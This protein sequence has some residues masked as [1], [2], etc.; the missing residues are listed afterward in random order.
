M[1]GRELAEKVADKLETGVPLRHAHRDYCGMG[2]A[3]LDGVFVYAEVNDGHLSGGA[4]DLSYRQNDDI[5]RREFASRA[6]FV[7]WLAAQSDESLSGRE[8]PNPGLHD[9]QRIT[10]ARL[11]DFLMTDQERQRREQQVFAQAEADARAKTKARLLA[12]GFQ[13]AAGDRFSI[14]LEGRSCHLV[15]VKARWGGEFL[16]QAWRDQVGEDTAECIS[17]E[18]YRARAHPSGLNFLCVFV[19]SGQNSSDY[20]AERIEAFVREVALPWFR[21][22]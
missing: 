9:N 12:L 4:G 15:L 5:E 22:S 2:L 10:V 11:H 13:W 19:I 8:L 21:A 14:L 3:V 18:P 17:S 16:I 1:V 6:Q 20:C 7:A